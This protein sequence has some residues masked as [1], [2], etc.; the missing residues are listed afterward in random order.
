[1]CQ[2]DRLSRQSRREGG[3]A[4]SPSIRRA[5]L[6]HR[7][8]RRRRPFRSRRRPAIEAGVPKPSDARSRT[9]GALPRRDCVGEGV[10][11]GGRRYGRRWQNEQFRRGGSVRIKLAT[12]QPR[13]STTLD[14]SA[15]L[16][17]VRPSGRA[18]IESK[19]GEVE[20]HE[21]D[22]CASDRRLQSETGEEGE[23]KGRRRAVGRTWR[24]G[25]LIWR[26]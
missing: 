15:R 10:R 8:I 22:A 18:S 17:V 2:V 4:P 19:A 11:A 1:M 14:P 26:R 21:S 5:R 6:E 20:V 16:R 7:A 12:G 25:G 24:A 3:T 13:R 9:R 23:G